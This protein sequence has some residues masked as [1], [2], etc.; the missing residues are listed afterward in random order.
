MTKVPNNYVESRHA[1]IKQDGK[2]SFEFWL[3]LSHEEERGISDFA[4]Q[5][6]EA[7]ERRKRLKIRKLMVEMI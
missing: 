4:V 3:F 6:P 5:R 1:N 7:F 2:K